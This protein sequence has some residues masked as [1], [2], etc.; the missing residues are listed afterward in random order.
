MKKIAL[1]FAGL[2]A[3]GA[4]MSTASAP[5]QAWGYGYHHAGFYGPRRVVVRHVYRP[6]FFAPVVVHR[7]FYR[8][9][10]VAWYGP[11]FYRPY[12][13]GWYGPRFV[14]PRPWGYGYGFRHVGWGGPRWGHHWGGRGYWR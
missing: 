13:V 12:R 3:L 9:R 14:G 10:P 2:V 4:G 5:A 6:A 1:A 8:P 11:G 7:R